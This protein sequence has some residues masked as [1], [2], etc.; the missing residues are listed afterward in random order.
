MRYAEREVIYSATKVPLLA[1]RWTGLSALLIAEYWWLTYHYTTVGL[2]EKWREWLNPAPGLWWVT[3]FSATLVMVALS[4]RQ[5]IIPVLCQQ[6]G[7]NWWKWVLLHGVAY[8]VF[9]QLTPPVFEEVDSPPELSVTWLAAWITVASASFVFWVFAFAPPSIWLR[10]GPLT[11][12]ASALTGIIVQVGGTLAQML[13]RPLAE[14]TLRFS[15]LLLSY[16]Y[17]GVTYYPKQGLVGT[18]KFVVEIDPACSGYE[19]I[20]LVSMFTAL[21]L[22]IFRKEL[23]FPKALFLFPIGILTIWAANILRVTALVVVGTSISPEIA[24]V[25]FHS[26]AGWLSFTLIGLGL[27]AISH[28]WW[29]SGGAVARP[30]ASENGIRLATVL[31]IPFLALMMTS[32]ITLAISGKFNAFYPL[33]VI[34]TGAVLWHYRKAYYPLFGSWSWQPPAIGAAVFVFWILLEPTR[35]SEEQALSVQFADWPSWLAVSWMVFRVLGSVVTIPLA[36]EL[37]FRGYLIR[38][39]VAR[40]FEKVPPGHFSGLSFVMSS[41]LFGLLHQRL[42]VGTLAGA[43]FALAL[44]RRGYVGDAVIAH[45]TSNALIAVAVLGWGYWELWM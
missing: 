19:G 40:N 8:A 23:Y 28:R 12:A 9:V 1:L 43:A 13:W 22:W 18:D 16:L 7:Y 14:A 5:I 39:L 33:H 24:V 34:I 11:L 2:P 45:A 27:I 4:R 21:Y 10:F 17:P 41:V 25:G 31:L 3:G 35:Q 15:Y 20:V 30:G 36:E 42:L 32:M 38:K 29:L 44:Y 37:A 6:T 26:Q